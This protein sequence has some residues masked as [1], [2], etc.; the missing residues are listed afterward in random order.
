MEDVIVTITETG[1]GNITVLDK[2]CI[3]LSSYYISIAKNWLV[4]GE[5]Y[6]TKYFVYSSETEE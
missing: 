4:A 2:T 1:T 6:E 3:M 5:Y